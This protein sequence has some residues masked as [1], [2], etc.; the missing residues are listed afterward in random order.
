MYGKVS[1]MATHGPADHDPI[2]SDAP[3]PFL[4]GAFSRFSEAELIGT[5]KFLRFVVES[6]EITEGVERERERA[7]LREFLA[8]WAR[9]QAEEPDGLLMMTKWV[10]GWFGEKVGEAQ[11]SC[12]VG[13]AAQETLMMAEKT[14]KAK[15]AGRFN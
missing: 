6:M 5:V 12:C 9:E 8:G 1:V 2:H 14:L 13:H 11:I 15:Y 10:W 7:V 4:H 3:P